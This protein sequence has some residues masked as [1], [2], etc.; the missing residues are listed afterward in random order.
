MPFTDRPWSSPESKLDVGAFCSVC[1]IDENVG[2]DK[3]KAKCYL[4]IRSQ[5][6]G[7]IN[8]NAVHAAA[9]VHGITRLKGV[10]A[11]VKRKAA[12]RLVRLYAEMGE[13]APESIY[14]VA[15]QARPKKT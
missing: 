8:K 11:D 4:P 5:P 10:S 9:G 7:P 2:R 3:I 14:R 6:G 15:G 13:V 12:K 1:L